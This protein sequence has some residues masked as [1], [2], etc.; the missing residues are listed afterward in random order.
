MQFKILVPLLFTISLTSCSQ[1]NST[2][3]S[4]VFCFDT[5]VDIKLYQGNKED[6]GNLEGIFE[7]LDKLTDN[8]QARDIP[9]V[10]SIN[11]TNEETYVDGD[12]YDL[13]E[14]SI[15]FQNDIS[16]YFNPLCGS[17]AKKWKESLKNLQILDENAKNE[18]I[19][20]INNSS[21]E[22]KTRP[23]TTNKRWYL[24]Q[25]SVI[26]HGEAE[27]DLGGVAKGYAL[28]KAYDYLNSK[29]IKNYLIDGG[30]SSILLGEK[31][32]KDGLFN[33]GITDLNNSYLKLK[34]CFVSTSGL[35]TQCVEIDGIKYSHIVNPIDGSAINKHDAVIV[36][37]N[38]GFIGD[39]LSTA[40]MLCNLDEIKGLE[41]KCNVQTIVVDNGKTSYVNENVTIYNH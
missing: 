19:V 13:L 36:I 18:E 39:A 34:N 2:L 11:Q 37:S 29:E 31:K 41:Q 1:S 3:A 5:M 26:R 28:D 7:Q 24:T 40:M 33:V 8:Y 32:S 25:G 15:G 6:I 27:I 23:G 17:L 38:N 22:L 10:Y 35:S 30:R 12:L 4:K 20:K 21:I 16:N 9:N 14:L